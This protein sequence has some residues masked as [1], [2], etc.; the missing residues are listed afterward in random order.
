MGKGAVSPRIGHQP[1]KRALQARGQGRGAVQVHLA[2][3][4]VSLRAARSKGSSVMALWGFS[5]IRASA[6]RL[7]WRSACCTSGFRASSKRVISKGK[8]VCRG[9]RGPGLR[10][11][12]RP[13]L[14]T[15]E[16]L[17]ERWW[18]PGAGDL[19][20]R[21]PQSPTWSPGDS[22]TSLSAFPECLRGGAPNVTE[23]QASSGHLRT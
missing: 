19:H 14:S 13:C 18:S 15:P 22:K 5:E 11:Q 10:P 8:A 4:K 7:S 3:L 20:A 23:T 21:T 1:S 17:P 9:R 16:P 12:R 6:T 2:Y